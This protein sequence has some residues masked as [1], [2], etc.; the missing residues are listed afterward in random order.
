MR[1]KRRIGPVRITG[2][3]RGRRDAAARLSREIRPTPASD[4]ILF[5]KIADLTR[6]ALF[7]RLADV[8]DTSFAAQYMVQKSSHVKI[9]AS[10]ER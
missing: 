8:K 1:Q 5:T 7:S 10:D 9:K 2:S 6:K 3:I 4:D